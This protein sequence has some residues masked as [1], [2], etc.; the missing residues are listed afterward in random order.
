M[1]NRAFRRMVLLLVA[2]PV[3]GVGGVAAY[4]W[5]QDYRAARQ[6]E[7]IQAV[8]A[9]NGTVDHEGNDVKRPVI[10]VKLMITRSLTPKL[11]DLLTRFGHLK[12]LNLSGT[13]LDDALLETVQGMTSLEV[14]YVATTGI[15]DKGVKHLRGLAGLRKLSLSDTAVTDGCLEDVAA[16]AELRELQLSSTAVTDAGVRRLHGLRNLTWID[17][18][19]TTVT[20]PARAELRKVLPSALVTPP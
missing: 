3:L 7:A 14:L 17:L 6:A 2:L 20:D 12:E 5:W 18:T 13:N 8:R 10:A 19:G 4:F 11:M 16:L 15:T 1:T 9:L